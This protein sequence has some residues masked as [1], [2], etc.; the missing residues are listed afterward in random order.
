V[1]SVYCEQSLVVD[2]LYFRFDEEYEVVYLTVVVSQNAFDEFEAVFR[3]AEYHCVY[4]SISEFE[5]LS[6]CGEEGFDWWGEGGA[7]CLE[8]FDAEGEAFG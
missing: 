3:S 2:G 7:V 5:G 6:G 1:I 4:C 8:Y